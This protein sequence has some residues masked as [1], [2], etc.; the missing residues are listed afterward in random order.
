MNIDYVTTSK[1]TK[2]VI[3]LKKFLMG[4]EGV[5]LVVLPIILFC[6]NSKIVTQFKKLRNYRKNNTLKGST[7]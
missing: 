5:L 6:D 2:K 3:W 4:L 1:V 7:T